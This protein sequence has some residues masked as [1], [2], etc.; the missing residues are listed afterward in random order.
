MPVHFGLGQ[1]VE[2]GILEVRWPSGHVEKFFDITVNQTVS[3]IEGQGI[4]V[5]SEGDLLPEEIALTGVEAVFPNPS[6]SL[7]SIRYVAG[8]PVIQ[9]IEVVN[10]LGQVLDT[11]SISGGVTG[12]STLSLNV[13][14]LPAG[15]YIV[16]LKGVAPSGTRLM[17]VVR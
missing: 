14:R 16:R 15:L 3:I 8:D 5:H 9:T 12:R 10:L 1:S 2:T 6:R 4:S 13:S 17:R 7:V 11:R